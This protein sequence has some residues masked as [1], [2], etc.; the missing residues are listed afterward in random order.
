[1]AVRGAGKQPRRRD[2]EFRRGNPSRY[3]PASIPFD[4]NDHPGNTGF[5][6]R[7]HSLRGAIRSLLLLHS[8][9]GRKPRMRLC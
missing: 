8:G 6:R 2:R 9:A 5:D 3:S 1:M 4:F 7:H